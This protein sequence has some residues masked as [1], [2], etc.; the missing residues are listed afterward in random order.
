MKTK[1][2][3][4]WQIE[5]LNKV[6]KNLKNNKSRDPQGYINEIFKPNVCGKNLSDSLLLL[7]NE[8]KAELI[9]RIYAAS[10]C[11]YYIQIKG[12]QNVS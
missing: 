8:I 7:A 9:P 1:K 4:K 11:D 3:E 2:S 5:D 12:V 10:K 6:L